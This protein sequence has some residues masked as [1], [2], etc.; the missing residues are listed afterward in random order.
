MDFKDGVMQ[1]PGADSKWGEVGAPVDS[2][3]PKVKVALQQQLLPHYRLALFQILDQSEKLD[4][5]FY[6]CGHDVD[7][8]SHLP[9]GS[10]RRQVDSV[11]YCWKGFY[12]QKGIISLAYSGDYDA[13]I[14][15]GNP[16][17]ASTWLAALIARLRGVPVLFWTHGWLKRE[18]KLKAFT[19]NLFYRIADHLLVYSNRGKQLGVESG[20]SAERL[21]VI[22]NSLD[23]NRANEIVSRIN[24]GDIDLR[25]QDLFRYKSRPLVICTARLTPLCRFDLLLRASS[26]LDGRGYPINILLVGDGPSRSMLED[27]A[28]EL[29]VEVHFAGAVYDEELIGPWIYHSDI[30]V[31]P[32]KIGLTAIH[33][34]M[35]GTAAITHGDL[36]LQMPEVEAII[37]GETGALFKRDDYLDLANKIEQWLSDDRDRESI[38]TACRRT[39]SETWSPWSQAELLVNAVCKLVYQQKT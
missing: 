34:L 17:Y 8:I 10:V 7:G 32:G 29:G 11:F 14:L 36:D 21:T 6:T 35:Y 39:V 16:N 30:T 33:S 2:D 38:R 18:G 37:D 4:I 9:R 24:S 31:S 28:E 15:M 12:W 20:Y 3:F 5:T 25:P 27:L 26:L 23:I 13:L 22:Y 1:P 19:R